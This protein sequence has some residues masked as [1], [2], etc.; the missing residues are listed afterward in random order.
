M[1]TM[2]IEELFSTMLGELETINGS[3]KES[4]HNLDES[5]SCITTT[6]DQLKHLVR[7]HP[8]ADEQEEIFFFKYTKPR[9]CSWSVYVVELHHILTSVPVGTDQMI[10]DYYFSDNTLSTINIT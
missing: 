5:L 3:M 7:R 8:F 10:R 6:I 9:F 1:M 4:V 2:D